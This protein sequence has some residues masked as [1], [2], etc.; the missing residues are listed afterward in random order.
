MR[1]LRG[2]LPTYV[3]C[4]YYRYRRLHFSL[5]PQGTRMC[6]YVYV[7]APPARV[8]A[9]GGRER[10]ARVYLAEGGA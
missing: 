2:W 4:F 3:P 6:R 5:R 8:E 10:E 7:A 9:S 1:P